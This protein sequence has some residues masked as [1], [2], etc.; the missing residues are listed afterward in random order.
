MKAGS[1][2]LFAVRQIWEG[3][4]TRAARTVNSTLAQANWLFGR[5]LVEAQQAGKDR[6]GYGEELL[7]ALSRALRAEY[8]TGSSA[9]GLRYRRGFYLAY[10][11][12]LHDTSSPIDQAIKPIH[13][14]LRDELEPA[15]DWKPGML[16]PSLSW[17][18]YR[19]LLKVDR[20]DARDEHAVNPGTQAW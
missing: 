1:G 9:S 6:A 12:L 15:P 7:L 20:R 13:H 19:A 10:P 8:G 14:A 4:R 2:L 16:H 3:A 11:D 17:T 5:Q 18:H